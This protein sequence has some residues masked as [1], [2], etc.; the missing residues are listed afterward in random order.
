M[1]STS[2]LFSKDCYNGDNVRII[3]NDDDKIVKT[4]IKAIIF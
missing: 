2:E 3:P 1:H 4:I